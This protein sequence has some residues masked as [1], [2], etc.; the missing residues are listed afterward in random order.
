MRLRS[1][2]FWFKNVFGRRLGIRWKSALRSRIL[3]WSTEVMQTPKSDFPLHF[4]IENTYKILSVW[5][6]TDQ[7]VRFHSNEFNEMLCHSKLNSSELARS[8]EQNS[9][10]PHEQYIDR[11]SFVIVKYLCVGKLSN[12]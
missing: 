1:A 11:R 2:D 4:D 3:F 6:T 10:L 8:F 5:I 9:T 12:I 7:F